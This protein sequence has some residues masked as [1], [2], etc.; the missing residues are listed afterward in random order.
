ML[1]SPAGFGQRQ[2]LRISTAVPCQVG[3]NGRQSGFSVLG[4]VFYTV[5]ARFSGLFALDRSETRCC[6]FQPLAIR[7]Q[8]TYPG[9][10]WLAGACDTDTSGRVYRSD[11]GRKGV[12]RLSISRLCMCLAGLSGARRYSKPS[13]AQGRANRSRRRSVALVWNERLQW[14]QTA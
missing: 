9:D 4:T 14:I 11:S 2:T 5:R 7:R 13:H 1:S 12:A 8:A 6:A 10:S 3:M